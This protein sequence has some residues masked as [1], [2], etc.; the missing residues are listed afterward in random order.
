MENFNLS[1]RI[2]G[3]VVANNS[4]NRGGGLYINSAARH[5]TVSGYIA[6]NNACLD[7]GGFYLNN[8]TNITFTSN[9]V[10]LY[11]RANLTNDVYR[12]GGIYRNQ[13]VN[14]YLQTGMTIASN[15]INA[16]TIEDIYTL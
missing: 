12:G 3:S 16:T 6:S 13:C 11:N 4:Q 1:N 9:A 10:I 7:G 5:V 8:M 15:Y 2:S 14:L